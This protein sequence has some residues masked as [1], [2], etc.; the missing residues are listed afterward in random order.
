MADRIVVL[1]YGTILEE[2]A[3]AQL[4][5]NNNLYAE[6]FRLQAEGYQ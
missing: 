4:L 5:L 6:M 1:Q 3:H 2:G